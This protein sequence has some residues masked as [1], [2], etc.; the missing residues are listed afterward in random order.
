M[1][2]KIFTTLVLGAIIYLILVAGSSIPSYLHTVPVTTQGLS[3]VQV[4]RELGSL[5]SRT[6]TII[7]P[8]TPDFVDAT[9]RWSNYAEPK[10]QL[11]IAPGEESDVSTIVRA[12]PTITCGTLEY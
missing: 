5:L 1:N 9:A 6:T 8:Q 4:Q 10:V 7:G 12:L 3:S 2:M 11:V